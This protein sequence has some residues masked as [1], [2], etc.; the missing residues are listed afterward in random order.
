M[1]GWSP[2]LALYYWPLCRRFNGALAIVNGQAR[3][4]PVLGQHDE[5]IQVGEQTIVMGSSIGILTLNDG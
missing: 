2:E 1:C 5:F 4:L 3:H